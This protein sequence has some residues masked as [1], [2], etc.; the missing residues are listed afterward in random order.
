MLCD[1]ATEYYKFSVLQI[2]HFKNH[3][4][5]AGNHIVILNYKKKILVYTK[6]V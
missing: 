6:N 5:G 1:L 4:L 3:R 2:F